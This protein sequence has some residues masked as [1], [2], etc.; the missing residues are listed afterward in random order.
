ML[1][2]LISITARTRTNHSSVANSNTPMATMRAVLAIYTT[3]A[4]YLPTTTSTAR[5]NGVNSP[6]TSSP[7][8]GKLPSKNSTPSTTPSTHGPP[9]PSSPSHRR[10]LTISRNPRSP[11]ST[12]A[13]GSATGRSSSTGRPNPTP[14]DIPFS[15]LP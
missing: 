13:Y 14:W 2:V 8:D 5:R 1:L 6:R 10:M 11:S 15:E 7:A 12:H 3:S 4:S 9:F